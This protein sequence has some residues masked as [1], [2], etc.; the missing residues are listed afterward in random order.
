MST[1]PTPPKPLRRFLANLVAIAAVS[2][3]FG[4]KAFEMEQRAEAG[5]HAFVAA[6]PAG[7]AR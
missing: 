2:T 3:I 7:T 5:T 4:A 1:F 6:G